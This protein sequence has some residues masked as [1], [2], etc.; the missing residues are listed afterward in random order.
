MCQ[1]GD[2]TYVL[3]LQGCCGSCC[4]TTGPSASFCKITPT[5]NAARPGRL[6]SACGRF[7]APVAEWHLCH[8]DCLGTQSWK[9]YSLHLDRGQWRTPVLEPRAPE[10]TG[11]EGTPRAKVRASYVR[12]CLG[13]TWLL[14][15]SHCPPG[16]SHRGW[17]GELAPGGS[18]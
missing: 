6:P 5:W 8:R 11:L 18:E 17:K 3:A 14:K 15:Q 12:L 10:K 16:R 7:C 2:R 9:S 4:A 1:A 13:R